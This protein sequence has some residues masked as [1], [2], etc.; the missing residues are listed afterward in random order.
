MHQPCQDLVEGSS[1]GNEGV[2]LSLGTVQRPVLAKF[3]H[4]DGLG[5]IERRQ[6]MMSGCL[7]ATIIWD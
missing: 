3:L 5:S 6:R 1:L 7:S 2:Q 4:S